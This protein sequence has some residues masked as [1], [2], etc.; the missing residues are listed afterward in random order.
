MLITWLEMQQL[1]L[2]S[3]YNHGKGWLQEAE[4]AVMSPVTDVFLLEPS[5]RGWYPFLPLDL[6]T[7]LHVLLQYLDPHSM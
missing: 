3:C 2:L 1:D 4:L 7:L 6:Y 5:V